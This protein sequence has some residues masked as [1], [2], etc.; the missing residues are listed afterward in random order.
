M[1][2]ALASLGGK[3]PLFANGYPNDPHAKE[4]TDVKVF[5]GVYGVYDLAQMWGVYQT[6]S[7]TSNNIA[8]FLGQPLPEKP[9]VALFRRLANPSYAVTANNKVAVHLSVGTEDDLQ[10]IARRAHTDAFVAGV[11]AGGLLR[12]HHD[13][14][15]RA[16]L[17]GQRADGRARQLRRLPGAA[18]DAVPRREAVMRWIAVVLA[19]LAVAPAAAQDYPNRTV[20]IV[21]SA[22][23]G[24]GPDLAARMIAEKLHVMWSQPVIVENRPG[25]GGNTGAEAVALSPPDGYTILAAQPTPLTTSIHLS[26]R[27]STSIHWRSSRSPS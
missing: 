25:N 19:L 15:R 6:Q 18:A 14:A 17:L 10:S 7:P 26:T 4:A 24:G 2:G 9:S 3:S 12:P 22:P 1:L 11:E 13:P 20:K 16:A 5:A 23:P 8:K 27:S 21:V